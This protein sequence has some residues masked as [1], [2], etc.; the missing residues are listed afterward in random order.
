[1]DLRDFRYLFENVNPICLDFRI[2]SQALKQKV[3]CYK[4][5][6]IDLVQLL[7]R[8]TE[9]VGG[10]SLIGLNNASY[11]QSINTYVLELYFFTIYLK[12]HCFV[13]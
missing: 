7:I 5:V 3:F 2:P 12:I 11:F 10:E 13:V 6:R 4:E 8:V 9:W 1:M